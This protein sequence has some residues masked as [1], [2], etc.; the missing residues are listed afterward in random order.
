MTAASQEK[1]LLLKNSVTNKKDWDVYCRQAKTKMPVALNEM[2][3]SSKQ[4][5]F[6]LWLDSGKDWEE[7]QLQVERKH[8]QR[9]IAT[10][11]WTA[12]QGKDLKKIYSAEKWETVK[13]SRKAQGLYYEDE[14][15]PGDDDDS[16]ICLYHPCSPKCTVVQ[17]WHSRSKVFCPTIFFEQIW[18]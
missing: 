16:W 11:G 18:L 13:A 3:L 14:D 5:L 8:Q 2:Y 17:I 12:K 6:N 7:C 1:A 9:H 4:E 10:R 15:F